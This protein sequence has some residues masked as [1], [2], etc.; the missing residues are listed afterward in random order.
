M[1]D[2][3]VV[4]V[5]AANAVIGRSARRNQPANRLRSSTHR[6]MKPMPYNARS[7]LNVANAHPVIGGVVNALRVRSVIRKSPPG[8]QRRLRLKRDYPTLKHRHLW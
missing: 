6:R 1:D 2:G 7:V 8:V 5:I 4:D 3:A